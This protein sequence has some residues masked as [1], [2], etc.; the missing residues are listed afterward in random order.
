M[1]RR[2][3]MGSVVLLGLVVLATM[4]GCFEFFQIAG[5]IESG[6]D[7]D[8]TIWYGRPP[9]TIC[10]K[11]VGGVDPFALTVWDFGDGTTGTGQQVTHTYTDVGEY[12]LKVEEI[13]NDGLVSERDQRRVSVA[14]DPEAAF[15]YGVYQALAI[16]SWLLPATNELDIEFDATSSYP[17][18]HGGPYQPAQLSWNF[19]DGTPDVTELEQPWF[20]TVRPPVMTTRH[21]YAAAGTYTVTL[22][23]TDNLGFSDTTRQTITVGT[24]GSPEPDDEDVIEQFSLTSSDWEVDDEEEDDCLVIYGSVMNNGPEDAGLELTATAYAG[25]VAVGSTTHWVAGVHNIGAGID[26]QYSFFLCDL[27]VPID[28]VTRVDV[29]ISDAQVYSEGTP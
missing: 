5:C 11:T 29:V 21:T 1:R 8:L 7:E 16:I 25:A 2:L 3:V 24:S 15:T 9:L 27:S 23:L 20:G 14:G 13:G 4:T 6:P 19:G 28:Q 26:Y 12:W 17:T 18:R 10:V 22:T